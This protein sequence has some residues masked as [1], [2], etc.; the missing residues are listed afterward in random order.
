M[1]FGAKVLIICLALRCHFCG[2]IGPTFDPNAFFDRSCAYYSARNAGCGPL[3]SV[4]T[5][6]FPPPWSPKNWTPAL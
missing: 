5:R 4:T 6:R 1:R 2:T 3:I